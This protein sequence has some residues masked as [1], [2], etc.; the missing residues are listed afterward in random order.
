MEVLGRGFDAQGSLAST[1]YNAPSSRTA[2]NTSDGDRRSRVA[3][4]LLRT[5]R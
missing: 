5:P 4:R 3:A 1:A 2:R